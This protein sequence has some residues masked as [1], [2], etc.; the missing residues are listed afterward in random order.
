MATVH[1]LANDRCRKCIEQ[2]R[3]LGY[4]GGASLNVLVLLHDIDHVVVAA[5]AALKRSFP[6]AVSAQT[7]LANEVKTTEMFV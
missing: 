5:K 4:F 6:E 7:K 3:S 1:V 2:E